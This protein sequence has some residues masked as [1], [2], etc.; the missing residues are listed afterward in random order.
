MP[1]RSAVRIFRKRDEPPRVTVR[2]RGEAGRE[3][4]GNVVRTSRLGTREVSIEALTTMAGG[5]IDIDP[6][7]RDGVR[8]LETHWF[9]EIR[10]DPDSRLRAQ[11]GLRAKVRFAMEPEPIATQLLRMGRQYLRSR[12]TS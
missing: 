7:S 10:P 11:P 5:S 1:D 6:S 4:G 9:V 8:A 12:L 2:V 3:I